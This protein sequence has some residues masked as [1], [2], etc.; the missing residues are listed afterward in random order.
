MHR[1]CEE[2][3]QISDYDIALTAFSEAIYS[4]AEALRK[5]LTDK[6]TKARLLESVTVDIRKFTDLVT[7]KRSVAAD[8]KFKE[9]NIEFSDF[10]WQSQ[11]KFDKGRTIFHLEH[12]VPVLTIRNECL[13]AKTVEAICSILRE[14]PKLVWILKAEN[15]RLDKLGFRTNR[16]DPA[17]A[18]HAAGI[19]VIWT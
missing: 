17:E 19:D 10:R 3:Q 5:R 16:L 4:K 18:Y 7:A 11:P 9:M 8:N 1:L 12:Y 13:S 15:E 6:V 2:E 14:R